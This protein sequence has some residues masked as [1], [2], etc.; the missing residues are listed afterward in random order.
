MK[1]TL[2]IF[3]SV[4][5]LFFSVQCT[6]SGDESSNEDPA[7]ELYGKTWQSNCTTQGVPFTKSQIISMTFSSSGGFLRI[8]NISSDDTCSSPESTITID[9]S[10]TWVG[11][12]ADPEIKKLTYI[13]NTDSTV[14]VLYKIEGT[15]LKFAESSSDYPTDLSEAIDFD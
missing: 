11:K 15:T 5:I 8:E 2:F 7:E 12:T 10:F 6:D 9:K 4:F 3:L 1:Y 14:Y 13:D